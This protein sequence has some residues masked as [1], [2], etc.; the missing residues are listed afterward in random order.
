MNDP[1]LTTDDLKRLA[2]RLEGTPLYEGSGEE[3]SM[4][5][6]AA[7]A[8]R[9]LIERREAGERAPEGGQP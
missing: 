5:E 7:Q 2:A 1:D 9:E 4:L 3:S 6:E 8:L